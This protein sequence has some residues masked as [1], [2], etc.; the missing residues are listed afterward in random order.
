[1]RKSKRVL[2][3]DP[4]S[5]WGNR[6]DPAVGEKCLID[7]RMVSRFPL[8]TYP[9]WASGYLST[10][11]TPGPLIREILSGLHVASEVEGPFPEPPPFLLNGQK[12]AFIHAM[13]NPLSLI[14]GP[15]G[16]GKTFLISQIA[17][18]L[19][20]VGLRVF[21]CSFSHRAINNAL[22]ACV[23]NTSLDQVAKIGGG[24]ANEDLDERVLEDSD[25]PG[26]RHDCI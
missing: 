20:N 26:G 19:V 25:C 4:Y 17:E 10:K 13:K 24:Y 23:R 14:Q 8:Y 15:P 21:I 2:L 6:Y 5:S 9:T 16:T 1:M 7:D 12:K 22:N 3:E 11:K 18:A